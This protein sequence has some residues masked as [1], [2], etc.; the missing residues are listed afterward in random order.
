L[1][2]QRVYWQQRGRIKWASLGDENMIFFHATATM[3]HNKNAI[4]M[5]R[6]GSGEEKFSHEDNAHILWEAYKDRL[7]TSEFSHIYFDLSQLLSIVPDLEQLQNPFSKEE[8]DNIIVN[9]PSGKSLG[10]DGFNTD[11]MKKCWRT[12]ARDFYELCKGFYDQDI[13]LQSINGSY[14][15]LIAK[16]DNP[17]LVNDYRHISLLN[18]SIKLLTKLLANRLRSVILDVV[19]QNQ[20]DFIRNRSIQYCLAWSFKYLHLCHKSKKEMII[21]K[22]DFEKAFDKIGHEVILKVMRQKGFPSRWI[23]WIKG[24]LSTGIS[25]IL[26]IGTPGKVFHCRRGVR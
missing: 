14:I 10:P 3:K 9:L 16:T 19:H 7:G 26:L 23:A 22:L 17:A 6:N 21:L 8:I 15:V 25:S 2:Q 24:I 5:L 13:Y 18:S 12:I 4:M 1:K 11:F 20:Y